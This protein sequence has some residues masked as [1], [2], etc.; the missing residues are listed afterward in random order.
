MCKFLDFMDSSSYT[1]KKWPLDESN[2]VIFVYLTNYFVREF[3]GPH[4]IFAPI[5]SAGKRATTA[6]ILQMVA[7]M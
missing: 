5:M 7:K 6:A 2:L 1:L 3:F 4:C